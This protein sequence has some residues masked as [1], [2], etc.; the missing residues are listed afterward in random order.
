M[1]FPLE[2]GSSNLIRLVVVL[3]I[4]YYNIIHNESNLTGN[5]NIMAGLRGLLGDYCILIRMK[6]E[7]FTL[8]ILEKDFSS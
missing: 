7:E 4:H 2:L 6:R 1:Y 8:L 5:D 3:I